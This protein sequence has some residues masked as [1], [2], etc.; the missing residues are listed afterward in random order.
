MKALKCT[1]PDSFLHMGGEHVAEELAEAA[2]CPG[3]QPSLCSGPVKILCDRDQ[4]DFV[5][6]KDGD[7]LQE[8]Q[9][10]P[11]P[12]IEGVY[13]DNVEV[14]FGDVIE[15][16]A[17]DRSFSDGLVVVRASLL[18]VYVQWFTAFGPAV[19]LEVAFLGIEGVSFYLREAG[20][21]DIG[22]GFHA[23]SLPP[24]F[25]R[26]AIFIA[27]STSV[28]RKES[29]WIRSSSDNSSV[30]SSAA[31]QCIR[32]GIS[33]KPSSAESTSISM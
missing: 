3:D 28:S 25:E 31:P 23:W 7:G 22:N 10:V 6:I 29:M 33:V 13:N 8:Y 1:L 20:D 24:V 2:K 32:M 16:L 19:L 18:P 9:E 15:K 17:E 4:A 11:G 27:I 12:A 30:Y 21:A 5:L 14:A 26:E